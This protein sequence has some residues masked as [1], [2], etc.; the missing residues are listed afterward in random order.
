MQKSLILQ[1]IFIIGICISKHHAVFTHYWTLINCFMAL[2]ENDYHRI[3]LGLLDSL[4][5][6]CLLISFIF[7]ALSLSLLLLHHFPYLCLLVL[8]LDQGMSV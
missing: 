4:L 5:C 7:H 8:N 1:I 3:F 6:F 2:T